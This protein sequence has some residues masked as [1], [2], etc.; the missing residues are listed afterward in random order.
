M[1]AD[2]EEG[3]VRLRGSNFATRLLRQ[4]SEAIDPVK[5][6]GGIMRN[7]GLFQLSFLHYVHKPLL[8]EVNKP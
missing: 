2:R 5:M 8:S 4:L 1:L 7:N 6:R 3:L